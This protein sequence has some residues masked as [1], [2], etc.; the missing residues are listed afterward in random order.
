MSKQIVIS[1]DDY[2]KLCE[3]AGVGV[4][5][6]SFFNTFEVDHLVPGQSKSILNNLLSLSKF[7]VE[8]YDEFSSDIA[9]DIDFR[10]NDF[11]F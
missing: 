11:D 9:D 6:D 5:L 10:M 2:E 3:L 8:L 1:N 7:A 4:Y